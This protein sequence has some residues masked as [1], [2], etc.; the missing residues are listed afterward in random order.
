MKFPLD[1]ESSIRNAGKATAPQKI[2]A[3]LFGAIFLNLIVFSQLLP[4][5]VNLGIPL[6]VLL[7]AQ[8]LFT[9]LVGVTL[10][11][12]F[13]LREDDK[14]EE[15]ENSKETSLSNY[16]YLVDKENMETVDIASI[17]E[18]SDGNFMLC[19]K[20]FYSN[21]NRSTADE[22]REIFQVILRNAYKYGFEVRTTNMPE[23][24]EDSQECRNFLNSISRAESDSVSECMRDI[25][26]GILNVC[27]E[28][29][30]LM[31][32][33]FMIRTIVPVQ[34]ENYA[35][36]VK[37]I[38]SEFSSREHSIRS[39][40]FLDRSSIQIFMRDYYG[41]EALDLSSLKTAKV[42]R[43]LLL[44][45]RDLVRVCELELSTGDF[46]TVSEIKMG[47]RSKRIF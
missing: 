31:S 32:T 45:L 26:D 24:F 2:G 44:E 6:L 17:F 39:I 36:L 38:M 43:D 37:D 7:L 30:S 42:S 27:G 25:A 12:Y 13:I 47:N 20:F 34:V 21:F 9:L 5:S 46:K 33:T 8:V 28:H 18:Y 16:Y 19:A 15:Y 1:V 11:R 40:S 14:V 4:F 35:L 3:I 23:K 10:F 29:N 41:L 22:T